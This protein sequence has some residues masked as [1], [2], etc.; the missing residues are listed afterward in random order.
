MFMM[1]KTNDNKVKNI[2]SNI[3]LVIAAITLLDVAFYSSINLIGEWEFSWKSVLSKS[4]AVIMAL[5]GLFDVLQLNSIIKPNP[6]GSLYSKNISEYAAVGYKNK[7]GFGNSTLRSVNIMFVLRFIVIHVIIA[8]LQNYPT[9]MVWVIFGV[10]TLFIFFFM[11]IT[12]S[13]VSTHIT[14]INMVL[15]IFRELFLL[16][17]SVFTIFM[18][19]DPDGTKYR[20]GT[21]DFMELSCV[22]LIIGVLGVQAL[23]FM[24]GIVSETKHRQNFTENEKAKVYEE[25][26]KAEPVPQEPSEQMNLEVQEDEV[27]VEVEEQKKKKINAPIP[28]D[29]IDDDIG[30]EGKGSIQ[31]I[32][33]H[34]ISR[35]AIAKQNSMKS[36]GIL[37]MYN[38]KRSGRSGLSSYKSQNDL[39]SHFPVH[40][41]V[42]K[43]E[44]APENEEEEEVAPEN[45]ENK[46][47][48]ETPDQDE[49]LNKSQSE[50]DL[51]IADSGDIEIGQNSSEKE[52]KPIEKW[53]IEGS[54]NKESDGQIKTSKIAFNNDR[55]TRVPLLPLPAEA[56]GENDQVSRKMTSHL[57]TNTQKNTSRHDKS[58]KS[59]QIGKSEDGIKEEDAGENN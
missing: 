23:I 46:N 33:S 16:A 56:D 52:L 55:K 45:E 54:E 8:T 4:T 20:T 37:K 2:F 32:K 42:E 27:E 43:E 50:D 31:T 35:H 47:T 21:R 10:I 12:I 24:N 57:N 5:M 59:L 36:E 51:V 17:F 25:V 44:V 58:M 9:I 13:N 19:T 26:N 39:I 30:D 29:K 48:I 53:K 49:N 6:S 40:T 18:N 1:K 22:W 3:H 11:K 14:I 7:E 28:E 15:S 41:E 38:R 34:Y